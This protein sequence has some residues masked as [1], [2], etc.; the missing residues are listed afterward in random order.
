MT[1]SD[2]V[3]YLMTRSIAQSLRQLSF[4]FT[5]FASGSCVLLANFVPL[6]NT[7]VTLHKMLRFRRYVSQRSATQMPQLLNYMNYCSV[8]SLPFLPIRRSSF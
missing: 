6:L 3:K 2:L 1:L 7:D 4:L 5:L 8:L